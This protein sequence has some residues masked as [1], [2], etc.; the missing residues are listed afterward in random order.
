M[1]GSNDIENA[2]I[3]RGS[4]K[5]DMNT[6][7]AQWWIRLREPYPAPHL[8]EQWQAWM[9]ADGSHAQAFA[10][11]SRL[12]QELHATDAPIRESLIK[13]FAGRRP[14]WRRW[15][16]GVAV[17]ASLLLA[18]MGWRGFEAGSLGPDALAQRYASAVGQ[19]RHIDL[20]DGSAIELGAASSLTAHYRS[21]RRAVNLD[22]GEAFFTVA[23]EPARP[24]VV[25]AGPVRIEDLGTAFNVRRTG[26]RVSVAV[27]QGRVRV[28]PSTWGAMGGTLAPR[29]AMELIAGQ[30]ASYDPHRGVFTLSTVTTTQATAWRQS[31]LEFVDEPLSAVLANVNRYSRRPVQLADPQLGTLTFTG[32]VNTHTIDS[33]INALPRVFPVEVSMFA[34]HVVL[35]RAHR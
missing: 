26:D 14:A 5:T 27:T 28:A 16:A 33:W 31:R 18:V 4:Y 10:Q 9:E 23:H 11:I 6:T 21:G 20:P 32:T 1:K 2:S 17:A 24:F 35:N 29:Q 30:Q 12:A 8:I 7:A 34:D 3:Q 25:D 15:M 13:E 22:D 19:D